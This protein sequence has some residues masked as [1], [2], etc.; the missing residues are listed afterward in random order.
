MDALFSYEL[1]LLL[2][3][4]FFSFFSFKHWLIKSYL[5]TVTYSNAISI[6]IFSQLGLSSKMFSLRVDTN[7]YCY[8]NHLL[9][10]MKKKEKKTLS[11]ALKARYY[12][13]E[14]LHH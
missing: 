13:I 7:Y 11:Y 8:S 2:Y 3:L 4:D 6:S 1:S 10:A 12:F 9:I 14:F 5:T